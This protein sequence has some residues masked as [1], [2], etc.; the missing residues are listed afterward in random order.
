M[1]LREKERQI[2]RKCEREKETETEDKVHAK[3]AGAHVAASLGDMANPSEGK[4]ALRHGHGVKRGRRNFPHKK[5]W[6][7]EAKNMYLTRQEKTTSA[8]SNCSWHSCACNNRT[9]VM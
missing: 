1:R 6:A 3:K 4:T 5:M 9:Q 8:C 7:I 2:E